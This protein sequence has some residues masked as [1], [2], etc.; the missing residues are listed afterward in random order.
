MVLAAV[1]RALPYGGSL[2]AACQNLPD[3]LVAFFLCAIHFQDLHKHR[4]SPQSSAGGLACLGLLRR[5]TQP[6]IGGIA[7]DRSAVMPSKTSG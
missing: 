6:A 5:C 1:R 7:G 2:A 4:R 3:R